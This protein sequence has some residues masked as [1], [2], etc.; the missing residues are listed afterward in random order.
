MKSKIFYFLFF[1]FPILSITAQGG[2]ITGTV[3]SGDDSLPL[4]G[5]TILVSGTNISTST[6]FDG[7]FSF[8]DI[9][10]NATTMVVSFVGYTP[11]TVSIVGQKTFKI[12]LQVDNNKLT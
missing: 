11:K 12:A 5:A 4:P 3:V 10:S 1:I 9:P 6:D 7:A 8:S 2:K